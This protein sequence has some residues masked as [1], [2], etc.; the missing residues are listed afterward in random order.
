MSLKFGLGEFIAEYH[1]E[2]NRLAA[3]QDGERQEVQRELTK[4]EREIRQI[5][6]AVK[7]GIRSPTMAAELDSLEK[8]KSTFQKR[9]DADPPPPVRLHPNLA[10]IYRQK[11]EN[12]HNALNRDDSRTEAAGILRNLIDEIRLI[13]RDG[14]LEIYL[15]GNLAEILDLCAKKN[16]GSKGAGVQTTLVAGAGFEPAT[17][18]L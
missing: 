10:E 13:P 4:V 2:I 7:S 17:F 15:V 8:R 1:R 16:P 5:I 18:R 12:L 3:T 6:D 9:L 11:I 14:Q